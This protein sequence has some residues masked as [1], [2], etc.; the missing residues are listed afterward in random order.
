MNPVLLY[1]G[2]CG[3][4]S[5]IVRFVLD[6]ERVHTLRFAARKGDTSNRIL[7]Q[8]K[9]IRDIDSV[10]WV[11]C[12]A[13]GEPLEVLVRSRAALRLARYLG[14]PWRLLA[15]LRL[16]PVALRDRVYDAV[17][18]NRHRI[19]PAESCLVPDGETRQ[20]FLD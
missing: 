4:C 19:A 12:D 13:A 8:Y 2:Q 18:R 14:G 7:L 15:V 16:I 6:H 11:E 9:E 3:L 5:S 20:R 1:D 10:V 17:A